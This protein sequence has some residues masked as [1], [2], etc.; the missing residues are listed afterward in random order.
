MLLIHS[1]IHLAYF[2]TDILLV[3]NFICWDNY[4]PAKSRHMPANVNPA[5][6]LRLES[7]YSITVPLVRF[8]N[9]VTRP[10]FIHKCMMNS[11]VCVM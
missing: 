10:D 3:D 1:F 2:P 6:E 11:V 5:Y 7:Q 9:A 4:I 8:N